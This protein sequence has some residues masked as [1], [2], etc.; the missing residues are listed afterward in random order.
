MTEPVKPSD[1]KPRG[2]PQ[3]KVRDDDRRG[4]NPPFVVRDG[5]REQVKE[6]ARFLTSRQIGLLLRGTDE[7]VSKDTICRHF[8]PELEWGRAH[9][10]LQAGGKLMDAVAAGD[11]QAIMFYLRT[12]GDPGQF[13]ERRELTGPGGGPIQTLDVSVLADLDLEE[14]EALERTASIF[15]RRFGEGD[16][17]EPAAVPDPA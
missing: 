6:W 16:T 14:L 11:R 5:E 15:A 8:G 10:I 13:V 12:Q 1:P 7:P 4:G 2:G 17:G 9:A 3:P